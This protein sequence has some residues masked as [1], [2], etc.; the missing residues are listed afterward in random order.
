MLLEI[1]RFLFQRFNVEI[2]KALRQEN[3]Y[4]DH[5][6]NEKCDAHIVV[7]NDPNWEDDKSY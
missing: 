3:I 5:H 1:Y 7:L 2:M 4:V 6:N